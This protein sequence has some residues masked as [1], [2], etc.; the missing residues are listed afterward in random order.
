MLISPGSYIAG[1]YPALMWIHEAQD[2]M[3]TTTQRAKIA[4]DKAVETLRQQYG[5]LIGQMLKVE[6]S[7]EAVIRK[8]A[9]P[10]KPPAKVIVPD[11]V[12]SNPPLHRKDIT[13][14][15]EVDDDNYYD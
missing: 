5:P 10:G 15:K 1:A 8:L 2:R 14:E 3:K 6:G 11:W 13:T 7:I 4:Y 12:D 9:R